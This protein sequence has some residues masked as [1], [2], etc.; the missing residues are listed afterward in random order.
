MKIKTGQT[1]Y[2]NIVSY[3]NMNIPI[4]G[5]TFDSNIYRDGVLY[6]GIT[7]N[8]EISDIE[9]AMYK[10]SW[11]AS[12]YGDYQLYVKNLSTSVIYQSDVYKVVSDDEANMTVYVGL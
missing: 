6:T 12:S 8:E 9:R 5:V 1:V 10:F 7:I 11:S 3:N 4:T 2:E